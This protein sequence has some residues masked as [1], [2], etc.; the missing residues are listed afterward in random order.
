M[1]NNDAEGAVH[2]DVCHGECH[3]CNEITFYM[4]QTVC[5]FVNISALKKTSEFSAMSNYSDDIL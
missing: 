5:L 2:R 3:L 1:T 4:V